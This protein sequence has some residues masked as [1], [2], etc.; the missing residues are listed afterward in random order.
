MVVSE[1]FKFGDWFGG[2]RRSVY[3]WGLM[4]KNWDRILIKNSDITIYLPYVIF[5][6]ESQWKILTFFVKYF[7]GSIEKKSI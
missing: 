2:V 5:D 1:F 6:S 7:N 4:G 3:F